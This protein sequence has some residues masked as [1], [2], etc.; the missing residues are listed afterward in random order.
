MNLDKPQVNSVPRCRC[1]AARGGA[2]AGGGTGM[3]AACPGMSVRK[4]QKYSEMNF[5]N[6]INRNANNNILINYSIVLYLRVY[7]FINKILSKVI[8]L[9]L[10]I[11]I[12]HNLR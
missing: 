5:T 7:E 4:R 6:Y 12:H 1:A 11:E 9:S 3:P 10:I 8:I 2:A